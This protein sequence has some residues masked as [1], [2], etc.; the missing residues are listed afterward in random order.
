MPAPT[1]WTWRFEDAS[2]RPMSV[3]LSDTF[4]SRADAESWIGE[5]WPEVAAQGVA[6]AQLLGGGAPVGGPIP[7]R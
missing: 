5:H 3:P 6:Q 4:A 2:A 7:L 1:T